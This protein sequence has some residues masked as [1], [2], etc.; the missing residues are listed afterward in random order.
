MVVTHRPDSGYGPIPCQL[1]QEETASLRA[2]L[3]VP[4]G[5]I[6]ETLFYD[7]GHT[8]SP[9]GLKLEGYRAA[10]HGV[11]VLRRAIVPHP[12]GKPA[13]IYTLN[14]GELTVPPGGTVPLYACL[15][16][17]T[18]DG[19]NAAVVGAPGPDSHLWKSGNR[20]V[21]QYI[22]V[23]L[24]IRIRYQ[25]SQVFAE[26]RWHPDLIRTIEQVGGLEVSKDAKEVNRARQDFHLI[27]DLGKLRPKGGSPTGPRK[28]RSW[29]RRECLE[30][31]KAWADLDR[32]PTQAML[33]A[34][35]EV[36]DSETAAGRWRAAQ[37]HWPPTEDEL[38][39]L[40]DS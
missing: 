36:A 12:S 31:W 16:M 23:T 14:G 27:D 15:T 24:S 9:T 40:E 21:L 6:L 2:E 38:A 13:Q 34:D 28:G 39:E 32:T 10:I 29:S 18:P 7:L 8:V 26:R 37:L 25:E 11:R 5:W 22:L 3:S 20:P 33:A 35:M 17:V 19:K 1:S 4:T 30:W